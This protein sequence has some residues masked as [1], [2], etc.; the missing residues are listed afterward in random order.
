MN[1]NPLNQQ[2]PRTLEEVYRPLN[3]RTFLKGGAATV[4]GMAGL[5]AALKPLLAL[6]KGDLT[7]DDLLQKHYREL[8]PDELQRILKSLAE[9]CEQERG[10][11]P[12]I[13]DLKPLDGVE[14]KKKMTRVR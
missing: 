4:A 5:V 2:S 8:K 6:E 10:V 14:F 12:T 3:R 9:K 13:R 11:H 1:E 7:L